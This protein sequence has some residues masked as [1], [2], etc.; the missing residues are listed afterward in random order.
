MEN[1]WL[2]SGNGKLSLSVGGL[3]VILGK[4]FYSQRMICGKY[5]FNVPG[6]IE[7]EKFNIFLTREPR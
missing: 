6:Q 3:M 4:L 7:K 1:R 5:R 2:I